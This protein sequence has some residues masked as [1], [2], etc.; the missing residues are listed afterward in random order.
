MTM[1]YRTAI[2]YMADSVVEGVT[3]D[4]VMKKQEASRD[5]LIR[6]EIFSRPVFSYLNHI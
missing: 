3:A 6:P 5:E 2:S 4:G 1:R